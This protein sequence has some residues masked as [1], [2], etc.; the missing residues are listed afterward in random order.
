ML[1]CSILILGA[2]SLEYKGEM[3]VAFTVPADG[4]APNGAKPSAGAVLS[5]ELDIIS[6]KFLG[7]SIFV[8]HLS[9][10]RC[11]TIIWTNACYC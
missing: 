5:S 4:L 8:N 7:L 11:Q 6:S 2:K 3:Y 10:D 9:P 1:C